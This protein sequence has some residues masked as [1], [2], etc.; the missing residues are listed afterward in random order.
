ML[1][2][3]VT[4]CQFFVT[5]SW[6]FQIPPKNQINDKFST[7][8]K[9]N[10]YCNRITRYRIEGKLYKY[11]M[12]N[13]WGAALCRRWK[14][15][16]NGENSVGQLESEYIVYSVLLTQQLVFVGKVYWGKFDLIFI[17][18]PKRNECRNFFWCSNIIS[19]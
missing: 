15:N 6:F 17:T 13:A 5:K 3:D 7:L 9:H 12:K 10:L 8:K 19:V 16:I 2:N 1:F 14:I 11:I 4:I 18:A